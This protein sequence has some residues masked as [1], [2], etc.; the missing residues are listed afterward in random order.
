MKSEHT[1]TCTIL[2]CLFVHDTHTHVYL[3]VQISENMHTHTHTRV[4][5]SVQI[6]EKTAEANAV[7]AEIEDLEERINKTASMRLVWLMSCELHYARGCE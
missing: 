7:E 6:S 1:H 2:M 4:Y 5:L 3:S